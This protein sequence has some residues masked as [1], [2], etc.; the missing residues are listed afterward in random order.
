[1]NR[2]LHKQRSAIRAS[3]KGQYTRQ[4]GAV[5]IISLIVLLGMTL[6]GISAMEGA[7]TEIKMAST[8][9]QQTLVLRR[10]EATLLTA[11]DAVD[12]LVSTAGPFEFGTDADGYYLPTDSVRANAIDWSAVSSEAGPTS[13][14]NSIDDDDAFVV[15]YFGARA[16]PG[17][18]AAVNTD[19]PVYGGTVYIFRNTT[20][21]AS[22]RGMVR[23]VQ[24]LYTTVD[25][26]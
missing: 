23:L 5:L 9:Q 17:E 4:R 19:A 14:S 24:S 26:P 13:T 11:E 21:S 10:A 20:R 3:S 15:E 22:G 2:A 7:L 12:S 16:I 8:M 25:A 18:S 6:I 1:M